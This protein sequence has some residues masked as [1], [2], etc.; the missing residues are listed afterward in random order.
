MTKRQF[1]FSQGVG[2]SA[3]PVKVVPRAR[4]NEIVGLGPD[5]TLKIRVTA[6]PVDGAA[7]QAVIELLAEALDIP[8]SNVD[9]VA[10]LT[11]TS[12]LV[13][14]TGISPS[15]VDQRLNINMAP[16]PQAV[17]ETPAPTPPK[18]ARKAASK[19]KG[20]KKK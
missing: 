15:L 13:S 8:K 1:Q 10:G 4:K 3:L 19:A 7:N 5:G 18:P 12:K 6:P 20:K 9:I 16:E 17:T 14:V 11:N 2:G